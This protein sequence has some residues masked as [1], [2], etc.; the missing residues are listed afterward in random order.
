MNNRLKIPPNIRSEILLKNQHACCICGESGVHIHH[1]NSN[2]SDNTLS[3]LAVLCVRHHDEATA[4]KGL[5]AKLKPE[6]IIKYKNRWEESC[7]DRIKKGARSRTAFFMVDYKNAERIRQIYSSLSP[8]EYRD[9]YE[10]LNTEL[11]EETVLREKQKYNISLEPTISWSTPVQKML[12][13]I[14]IGCI[15]PPIFNGIKG[16]PNDPFLPD[17][18]T[19]SDVRVAYFDMWCQLMVRAIIAVRTPYLLNDLLLLDDPLNSGLSGVLVAFEAKL[20]GS[21]KYPKDWKTSPVT[22]T[23]LTLSNKNTIIKSTLY[24]KTHYIYSDTAS[25]SLSSGRSYGLLL[26]RDFKSV[27]KINSKRVVEFSSI[28]III[29]CGGGSLLNIP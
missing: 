13:Y 11:R 25:Q 5:T 27:S 14:K 28:P 10:I 6:E 26:F 18:P 4:P 3:N 12:D 19:F 17:I 7:H 9:A 16:H 29:G 2:P 8:N 15:H 20:K 1:I 22:T 23:E 24:F 21:V